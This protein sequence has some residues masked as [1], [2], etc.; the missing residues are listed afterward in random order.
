ME[1][2]Y[3][4]ADH[5]G[6]IDTWEVDIAGDGKPDRS[7]HIENPPWQIV[8]LTYKSMTALYNSALDDALAQNQTLI[9]AMKGVLASAEIDFREEGWRHRR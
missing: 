2:R 3:K 9:D 6:T 1:F 5:D 4:D 8:P 7:F